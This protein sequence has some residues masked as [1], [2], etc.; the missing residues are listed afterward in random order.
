MRRLAASALVGVVTTLTGCGMLVPSF[1]GVG[2]EGRVEERIFEGEWYMPDENQSY[3][4]RY[5]DNGLLNVTMHAAD[6]DDEDIDFSVNIVE[7]DGKYLFDAMTNAGADGS[8]LVPM[9]VI[10]RLVPYDECWCFEALGG[11]GAYLALEDAGMALLDRDNRL[12][13]LRERIEHPPAENEP[14]NVL[15]PIEQLQATLESI[16]SESVE[17]VMLTS[18]PEDIRVF[19]MKDEHFPALYVPMMFCPGEPPRDEG[20]FDE[21]AF[22]ELHPAAKARLEEYEG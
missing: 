7:H 17:G 12:A 4:F 18:R 16:N 21:D 13:S 8:F 1:Y 3:S 20:G 9:H 5:E 15:D 22:G 2:D 19:L 14:V 11:A 6:D 10:G